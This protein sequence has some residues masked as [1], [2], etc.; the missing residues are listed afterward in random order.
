M[1][2][3]LEIWN[4]SIVLIKEIYSVAEKLPQIEDYNL[5][6]QLRRAITSVSLNIAES[7]SRSSAK[8]FAHFLNTASASLYEV[9]AIL[10]ICSELNYINNI[11]NILKRTKVLNKKIN[12]LRNKLKRIMMNSIISLSSYLLNLLSSTPEWRIR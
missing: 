2:K 7:K 3:K 10:V 6:T 4:E 8:E 1:F 5:K 9:D 11:E 12:A